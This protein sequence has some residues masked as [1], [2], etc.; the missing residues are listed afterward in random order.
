M[1]ERGREK[2]ACHKSEKHPGLAVQRLGRE[3]SEEDK[4]KKRERNE[5]EGDTIFFGPWCLLFSVSKSLLR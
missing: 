5:E 3:G 2:K 4:V 1:R